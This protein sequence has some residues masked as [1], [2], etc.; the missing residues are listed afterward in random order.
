MIPLIKDFDTRD[1]LAIM[2]VAAFI[3]ISWLYP[4]S[5]AA[6]S[7]EN[8]S[9]IILGFYFGNKSALDMPADSITPTEQPGLIQIPCPYIVPTSSPTDT[10]AAAAKIENLGEVV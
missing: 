6:A 1:L 9:L 7:M 4:E 8:V 3:A 5:S 2:L 10:A